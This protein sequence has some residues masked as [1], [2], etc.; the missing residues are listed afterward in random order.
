MKLL[1]EKGYGDTVFADM[2]QAYEALDDDMKKRLKGLLA[3]QRVD[4]WVRSDFK[5][6]AYQQTVL[7]R[8]PET[9]RREEEEE[10]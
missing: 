6:N 1:P 9:V 4:K 5:P 3:G 7:D 2:F 10:M 8:V